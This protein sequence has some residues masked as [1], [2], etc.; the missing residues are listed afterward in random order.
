MEIA[1]YF[2]RILKKRDL[3]T[4]QAMRKHQRNFVMA[5]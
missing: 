1:K 4:N 5:A 3:A 2:E